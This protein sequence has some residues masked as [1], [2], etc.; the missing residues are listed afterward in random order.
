MGSQDAMESIES[1]P[2]VERLL[3]SVYLKSGAGLRRPQDSANLSVSH[4][5][6]TQGSF[7]LSQVQYITKGQMEN[8]GFARPKLY[9]SMLAIEKVFNIGNNFYY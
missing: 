1:G 8:R 3:D 7:H 9:P 2:T 6:G 4:L 5:Q